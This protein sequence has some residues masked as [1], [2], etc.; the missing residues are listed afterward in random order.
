VQGHLAPAIS[1][2]GEQVTVHAVAQIHDHPGNGNGRPDGAGPDNAGG[3]P[4]GVPAGPPS[5]ADDDEAPDDEEVVDTAQEDQEST[6]DEDG[7]EE[8]DEGEG[9]EAPPSDV[10]FTV[11]YGDGSAV[12]VMRPTKTRGADGSRRAL[13]HHTYEAEGEYPVTVTATPLEGE[14]TTIELVAQVGSGAARLD[15]DDRISTAVAISGDNFA[16]GA[17]DAVVLARADAFADALAASTLA[18]V[19]GAPV[20]LTGS[21]ELPE[22]VAD[23]IFR[24]LADGGTVFVLGG[25]AAISAEVEEVLAGDY[26]VTRLAEG[27]RIG[28][29]L[30]V[31][32]H[33]IDLGATVDQVVVASAGDFP[34]ALAGAAY[35]AADG[36]LILLTGSD[37][38]DERVATMLTDLAVPV[39]VAGGETAV[40]ADVLAQ[41]GDI[42]G[43]AN[44]QRIAGDSRFDTAV[45]LAQAG[46]DGGDTVILATGTNYPDVLAGAVYEATL[47]TVVALGGEGAVSDGLISAAVALV[48]PD[49]TTVDGQP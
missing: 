10:T 30:A 25:E 4:E 35:A 13:A 12:E 15:G 17:A 34:D 8:D 1:Q 11:D 44:V 36:G 41:I 45:Q 40:S 46:Y 43:A 16:D 28:T 23:E 19:S 26:Q 49:D 31:A 21:D 5:G 18:Y 47:D 27:D 32:Q 48:D 14:P 7:V 42:V 37:E 3:P 20:L 22:I 6:L 9:D 29:A 38:L 33:V 2:A 39:V 24:V